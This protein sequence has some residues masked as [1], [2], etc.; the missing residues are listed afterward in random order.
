MAADETVVKE[1]ITDILN[2][3]TAG[4][5]SAA[6]AS[7][8]KDRHATGITE[9]VREAALMIAQAICSNPSHPHRNAFIS[10]TPTALTHAGELP[11]LAGENDL[12][13]IETKTA[14]WSPGTPRSPQQIHDYRQN[15]SNAY[16][17]IAH[18]ADGSPL[19]GYYAI[20]NGRVYFTGSDARI[21]IPVISRATAASL[22]PDEYE[23]AWVCLGAGLTPKE[24]DNML[25]IS[26]YY[27]SIGNQALAAIAS[28]SIADMTMPIAKALR[29]RGDV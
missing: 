15:I 11:D 2:V 23:G 18:D 29:A 7:T 8:N 22:I 13:E 24:G 26:Q 19:S 12:I 25:P 16:S 3:Q 27:M 17:S 1:R 9:A 14:T 4:T 20:H 10:E 5:W 28:N 21:Y 6:V